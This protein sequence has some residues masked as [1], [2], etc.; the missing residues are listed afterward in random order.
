[1]TISANCVV[2]GTHDRLDLEIFIIF[3]Q[4]LEN[5]CR[6][7]NQGEYFSILTQKLVTKGKMN[8][9]DHC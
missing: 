5:C 8:L 6:I 7:R 4:I 2:M 1:M 3:T 9:A